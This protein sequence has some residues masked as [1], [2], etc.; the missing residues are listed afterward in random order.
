[1]TRRWV[2][3]ILR[4][5]E[6]VL[7]QTRSA[8]EVADCLRRGSQALAADFG[9]VETDARDWVP[10]ARLTL[11][12]AA[13]LGYTSAQPGAP[14]PGR[15]QVLP[16]AIEAAAWRDGLAGIPV[17]RDGVP[18]GTAAM[19][20]ALL[21]SEGVQAGEFTLTC[22]ERM[23]RHVE[24][25]RAQAF[26]EPAGGDRWLERHQAAILLARAADILGDLRY[27]NGALKLND[28]AFPSHRT[29]KLDPGHILFLRA[30]AEQEFAL[31]KV[32]T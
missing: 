31:H 4:L 7:D 9:R 24:L 22:V 21:E 2:G 29:F 26:P 15:R 8:T 16:A 11:S 25:R 12:L 3:L 5:G 32:G 17:S 30:L 13:E 14:A 28:L 19:L 18:A 23:L 1:M 20:T 6:H 10:Q 27:L